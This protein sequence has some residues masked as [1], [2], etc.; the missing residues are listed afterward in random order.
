[1]SRSCSSMISFSELRKPH[2]NSQISALPLF[3]SLPTIAA[4]CKS[5]TRL[6]SISCRAI[7]GENFVAS[8][9]NN[10]MSVFPTVQ[11]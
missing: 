7:R 10:A 8:L 9:P 4:A 1:M 2:P 5:I 3:Y 11:R 6:G